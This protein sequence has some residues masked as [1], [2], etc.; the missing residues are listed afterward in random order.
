MSIPSKI[1]IVENSP[2][3][4]EFL[5]YELN[6]GGILYISE[7]VQNEENYIN[8]LKN[9]VPDIILSD[10]ALPSFSGNQAFEIRKQIAPETPFIFVSGTIGEER[11]IEY[12][13]NGVTD[14]V[15][16]DKLFTL[17]VKIK[18]ALQD[19]KEKEQKKKAEEELIKSEMLFRALIERST[20]M[21]TLS[22]SDGQFIYGSPSITEI[23][24]YTPKDFLNKTAV[25]FLHES[26]ISN[27]IEKRNAISSKPGETFSYQ[28]RIRHKNGTWIWCDGTTTNMLHEPGI[29]AMV[30]NLK[31]ISDQKQA[32]RN[33][34]I[35]SEYLLKALGDLQKIMDSS[36][37][38]IC[39][40]DEK[41][42]FI[43]VSEAACRILGYESV[44]LIGEKFSDFV[45]VNEDDKKTSSDANLTGNFQ[46]RTFENKIIHKNGTPVP[47]LWS[48]NRDPSEKIIYCIA[49]DITAS[50]IAERKLL[51]S[52]ARLKEAQAI[53]Q[54]GHFD[55]D[56]RNHEE[57]WSDEMFNILG[58]END[59]LSP[60]LNLFLTFVH[61][62][63]MDVLKA[64]YEECLNS[65][66]DASFNFRFIRKDGHLRYGHVEGRFERL[67]NQKPNR[68]FGIF[69]DVTEN[70]IAEAVREKLVHDLRLRNDELE[71]FAYVASHDL[72]E[73]LRMISSFMNLLEKKFGD[74]IDDKGKQYIH[75]AVDGANRMRE[76]ILDLLDF[77]RVGE[78]EGELN[79]VNINILISE[80]LAFYQRKIEDRNAI[81]LYKGLPTIQTYKTPVR[82]V[83]QNLISNSLKYAK[84]NEKP[85]IEIA[86]REMDTHFQFSVTDNGIGIS[87]QY[88][89]KIFVIFQRLHNKNEYSGTGMGLAI[90]KKIVE[91]LGGKIWVE[92][93]LGKGSTFYFTILKNNSL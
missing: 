70:K 64:D 20:D 4:V 18:R 27:F 53:A 68:L 7:V 38:I 75:F 33:L 66:K 41:G 42:R 17:N 85:V 14:Y 30:S 88:F 84:A 36:L 50:K 72:Q 25:D 82:Q 13:K 40:I 28:L 89:D 91:N 49:K 37:D 15:L 48:A 23:L 76:I 54:T 8:A 87:P 74:I 34:N 79:E 86:C 6:K 83:F 60:S 47:M 62:G 21:K 67:N 80:I 16:K 10:Y 56:L 57:V 2:T 39:S 11:S 5:Q 51:I 1:L 90:V 35:T 77:S 43:N 71:Q 26:D 32:E 45:Y 69:Q 31:D 58:I 65:L 63:D 3:D 59:T 61:P 44:D 81:I 52:E 55:L 78:T 19:V 22:K 93:E 92:S 12:I 29:N 24:G 46:V 73:P 9:F